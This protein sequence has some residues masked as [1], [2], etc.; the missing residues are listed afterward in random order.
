MP[1]AEVCV[2]VHTGWAFRPKRGDGHWGSRWARGKACRA[3]TGP[4]KH[5]A[6]RRSGR[7]A[8]RFAGDAQNSNFDRVASFK[9]YATLTLYRKLYSIKYVSSFIPRRNHGR[10][11][12]MTSKL[13]GICGTETRRGS[14]QLPH[15]SACQFVAAV[16]RYQRAS[17]PPRIVFSLDGP[18]FEDRRG[19]LLLEGGGREKGDK[20]RG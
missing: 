2:A 8:W 10:S 15:K 6:E 5:G 11:R 16:L 9:I 4:Q 7:C 3:S 12:R 1:V 17:G 19:A 13:C 20:L 18:D 14:A